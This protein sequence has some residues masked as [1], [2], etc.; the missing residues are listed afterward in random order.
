MKTK[1]Y[2]M[3]KDSRQASLKGP[4]TGRPW[5]VNKRWCCNVGRCC[6][7]G[8][9]LKQQKLPKSNSVWC[10]C[11]CHLSHPN[12]HIILFWLEARKVPHTVFH[13]YVYLE[14]FLLTIVYTC[15]LHFGLRSIPKTICTLNAT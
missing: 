9:T 15:Q 7:I 2:S 13:L 10:A 5:Y 14:F 4:S 11:S 8:Q 1:K 3:R 6:S 12:T